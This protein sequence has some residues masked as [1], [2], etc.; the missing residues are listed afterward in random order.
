MLLFRAKSATAGRRLLRAQRK[1]GS[2]RERASGCRSMCKPAIRDPTM[3]LYRMDISERLEAR[4]HSACNC[5]GQYRVDGSFARH[6][7]FARKHQKTHATH[8]WYQRWASVPRSG[9]SHLLVHDIGNHSPTLEHETP[10]GFRSS[11]RED[12]RRIRHKHIV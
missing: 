10:K 3:Q 11:F 12:R 2:G 4:Q 9:V 8:I 5:I 6:Y 1:Q 7:S